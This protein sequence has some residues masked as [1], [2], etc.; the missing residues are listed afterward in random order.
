M[1]NYICDT[2]HSSFVITRPIFYK[3]WSQWRPPYYTRERGIFMRFYAS[4][5]AHLKLKTNSFDNVN[6]V[7]TVG[8]QVVVTTTCG[9]TS[10]DK[11]GIMATLGFQGSY[12]F[13]IAVFY[14]TSCYTRPCYND[15]WSYTMPLPYIDPAS[16]VSPCHSPMMRAVCQVSRGQ[17]SAGEGYGG[18]KWVS[19]TAQPVCIGAAVWCWRW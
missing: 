10:D 15:T 5:K 13:I 9:A 7:V 2:K 16:M 1:S 12:P 6:F 17:H 14:A 11:V 3:I 19:D 8:T 4:T 18:D